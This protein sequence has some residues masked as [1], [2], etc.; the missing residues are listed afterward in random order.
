MGWN[1]FKAVVKFFEKT[2]D[3]VVDVFNS[4]V[5]IVLSPFGLADFGTPDLSGQQTQQEILGPLLN[6]DSGVGNIPIVYGKRRVGGYRVFVSTNGTNNEYLYV[7]LV[8]SEGQIDALEKIY[9]DDVEVPMSS[10]A[11]GTQ[12]TPSSGAYQNRVVTQ[13]FDGRDDQTVSS[14]LDEAPGWDSNHRLRGLA[15]L[16]IRF[17]WL[18]I[19]SQAD[20]DNNP[21]RSG[22]PSINCIIRGKKIFDIISGYSPSY[23]GTITNAT[24][25]SGTNAYTATTAAITGTSAPPTANYNTYITFNTTQSDAQIRSNSIASVVSRGV[26]G[27]WQAVKITQYLIDT[28]TSTTVETYTDGPISTSTQEQVTAHI[29]KVYDVPTGNYQLQTDIQLT[30]NGPQ[31]GI[32]S[33][34]YEVAAEMLLGEQASHSTLYENETIAY[35]NNPVNVLLDYCRNPRFGK[36]LSNDVFNWTTFRLAALQCDQTV[37]YTTSTTGKFSEFDGVTDTGNTLLNNIRNILSSFTG[38]MPYQSGQ[39]YLKIPHGGNDND[40]D[41]APN[42]PPV[43]MIITE[44]ILIGGMKIQ[45]ESKDRKINQMRI[46]Y[47]DPDA[48]Y[49]PNDVLWPEDSSA[50]YSTYLSEDQIPLQRQITLGN[51]TNRERALNYGETMVKTSRNKMIVSFSTTM[52]ASDLSVGDLIR[53]INR[54]LNFDGIF[55][56]ETIG[57]SPEGSLQFQATEHNSSD[58]ILDGQ[59]A[60]PARPT[61][62]LP[63][64]LQVSAP[65]G[66]TVQSGAAFNIQTNTGGYLTEDST[67]TRLFVSWVASTDPYVTEYIIQFKLSADSDWN[68]AGITTATEFFIAPVILG[69]SYDVRV[70]SRNELDRRSNFTTV[71]GHTVS[72]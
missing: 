47:T 36:G 42:P 61:I 66:L 32:P 24:S 6:K 59:T 1:P 17:R 49:Q 33:G 53:L 70:A 27:E 29:D 67:V 72:S 13:F 26:A 7:A 71:T 43:E 63:D 64:P 68:T 4:V 50:T 40:I 65:T 55:R 9:I 60:A 25:T 21:F 56:I 23:P 58:Y 12:A 15:Y 69:S 11:H 22:I 3:F 62:F 28:D 51:C 18:K 39:Y 10:Y 45:G 30:G 20:A 34:S 46:T 8:L 54:H 2:V 19:E 5:D 14:L 35:S 52:A 37:P 41:A 31:V 48:D 38:I 16:A 44:D 57:L